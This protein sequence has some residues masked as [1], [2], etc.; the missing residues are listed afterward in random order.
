MLQKRL[1]RRHIYYSVVIGKLS[2]GVTFKIT[3]EGGGGT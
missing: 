3:H 1:M 2:K